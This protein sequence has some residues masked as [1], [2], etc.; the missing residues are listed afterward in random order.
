ME[1]AWRRK[2]QNV[3][4][5]TAIQLQTRLLSCGYRRVSLARSGLETIIRE[6]EFYGVPFA[7]SLDPTWYPSLV[8]NLLPLSL[9]IPEA[10]EEMAQELS[11]IGIL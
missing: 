10:P 11:V 2:D 7:P 6:N 9:A 4:L 3:D 8:P 5:E 1:I